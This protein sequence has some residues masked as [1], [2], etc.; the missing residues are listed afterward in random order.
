MREDIEGE[1]GGRSSIKLRDAAPSSEAAGRQPLP[2]PPR[3]LLARRRFEAN[4]IDNHGQRGPRERDQRSSPPTSG[5]FLEVVDINDLVHFGIQTVEYVLRDLVRAGRREGGN[6]CRAL[7][8][9][10]HLVC[11]VPCEKTNES[12]V[13][14]LVQAELVLQITLHGA[15]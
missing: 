10:R 5:R 1:G 7:E 9:C 15:Q 11:H 12:T 8:T 2:Y 14:R 3:R 13:D 4:L 6:L